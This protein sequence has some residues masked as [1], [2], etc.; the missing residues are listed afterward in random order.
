[1]VTTESGGLMYNTSSGATELKSGLP[2]LES[3]CTRAKKLID[4]ANRH[5]PGPLD[6]NTFPAAAMYLLIDVASEVAKNHITANQAEILYSRIQEKYE[7]SLV[8]Y[9]GIPSD[10]GFI[11]HEER[12]LQYVSQF[13]QGAK[14]L[15][16]SLSD[17]RDRKS[18]PPIQQPRACE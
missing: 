7:I 16:S 2:S 9:G 18:T 1:M 4:E 10:P 15:L 14:I 6:S 8:R 12:K 17:A 13:L 3:N 11:K 5:I